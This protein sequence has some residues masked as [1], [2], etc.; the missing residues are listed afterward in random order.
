MK[1]YIFFVMMDVK[2]ACI[3]DELVNACWMHVNIPFAP[4]T[5]GMTILRTPRKNRHHLREVC[6][7]LGLIWLRLSVTVSI[8]CREKVII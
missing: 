1:E 5:V 8:P 6:L 4:V 7:A 2:G 3:M